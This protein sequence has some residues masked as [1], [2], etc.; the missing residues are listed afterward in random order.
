MPPGT[1]QAAAQAERAIALAASGRATMMQ[2]AATVAYIDHALGFDRSRAEAALRE[3][4]TAPV[5]ASEISFTNLAIASAARFYATIGD[6][7][8]AMKLGRQV[9]QA[10]MNRNRREPKVEAMLVRLA[11]EAPPAEASE[12]PVDHDQR[13]PE[14]VALLRFGVEQP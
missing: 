2:V 7:D 9:P 1:P 5:A 10:V 12:Q 14:P 11:A 8:L 13:C 6:L 3:F 4:L